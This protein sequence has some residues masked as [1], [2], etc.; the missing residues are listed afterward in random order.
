MMLTDLA[1]VLRSAGLTVTEQPGWKTRGHG[2]MTAVLGVTCH[3][4]ANG[5]AAGTAPSLG[6]VQNGRPGLD[7]PLAHLL[8]GKDGTW[9]VVAAGLCY[10]A[11]ESKTSSTTHYT[12]GYRIGIE[13]EA[14]GIPGTKGDWPEVQMASY[15]RGA[16][17]LMKRYGFSISQVLGHKET[18]APPGRKSDPDFNMDAFRSRVASV[19]LTPPKAP[20]EPAEEDSVAAIKI[21]SQYQADVYNSLLPADDN[22]RKKIGDTISETE[23]EYWGNLGDLR[24]YRVQL[25]TLAELA[26]VKELLNELLGRT[27]VPVPPGDPEASHA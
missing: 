3:H 26:E 16:K 10:H 1:D 5:G 17:A 23:V 7:G 2:Q 8:L 25:N 12:N 21:T 22:R 15:A 9:H 20:A 11:G 13:A 27:P 14:V 6:V 19:N 18:C 24:S 4:T